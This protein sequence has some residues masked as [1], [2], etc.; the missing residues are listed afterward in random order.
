MGGDRKGQG[1]SDLR[2]GGEMEHV[3]G[4]ESIAKTEI[5]SHHMS[6]IYP[7]WGDTQRTTVFYL[8]CDIFRHIY[9]RTRTKVCTKMVTAILLNGPVQGRQCYFGVERRGKE[10]GFAR[11][12]RIFGFRGGAFPGGPPMRD[13]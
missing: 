2:D 9:C 5:S 3:K 4:V 11:E 6:Q 10:G 1:G 8:P 12:N 7:G 13:E